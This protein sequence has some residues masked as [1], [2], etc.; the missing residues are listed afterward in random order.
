MFKGKMITTAIPE[1][2]YTLCKIVEKGSITSNDLKEKNGP[3]FLKNGSLYLM[4]IRMQRKN[5][6]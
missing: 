3:E 5:W 4:I 6:A 2:V 1:R